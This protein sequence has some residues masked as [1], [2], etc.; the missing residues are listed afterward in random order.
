MGHHG[1]IR[2][3][4]EQAD[5]QH[6]PT[7][8]GLC[9]NQQSIGCTVQISSTFCD[10]LP[11][12]LLRP[13]PLRST[14]VGVDEE[15][16]ERFSQNAS[17]FSSLLL[18]CLGAAALLVEFDFVLEAIVQ[19]EVVV[20]QSGGGSRRESAVGARAVQEEAGA[21]CPEQDAQGAHNDDR[22]QNGV[23]GV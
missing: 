6:V 22:D 5:R 15:N 23:Q 10:M 11:M 8:F 7:V 18:S 16:R 1:E 20:L 17:I 2:G 21:H 3:Q 4:M 14:K 12:F 19:F 9:P 13:A